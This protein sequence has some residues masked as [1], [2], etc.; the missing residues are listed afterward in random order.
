MTR[1]NTYNGDRGKGDDLVKSL[2]SITQNIFKRN[3]VT[4]KRAK[5]TRKHQ[6]ITKDRLDNLEK[7]M[8]MIMQSLENP[9]TSIANVRQTMAELSKKWGENWEQ[10]ER[11]HGKHDNSLKVAFRVIYLQTKTMSQLNTTFNTTLENKNA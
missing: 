1:L 6:N 9:A 3:K 10:S 2:V 4:R 11:K 5:A 8:S 7:K